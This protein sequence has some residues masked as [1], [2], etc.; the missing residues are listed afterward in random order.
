M[1]DR[2]KKELWKGGSESEME[3]KQK[4]FRS[5]GVKRGRGSENELMSESS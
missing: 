4:M 3:D 5:R 2:G 1:I